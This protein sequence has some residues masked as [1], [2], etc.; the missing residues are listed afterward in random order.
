MR[1]LA[2]SILFAALGALLSA[3]CADGA[4]NAPQP[5]RYGTIK[6]ALGTSLGGARAW[7]PDQRAALE[8]LVRELDA[9]GPDFV[10]GSEADPETIVVRPEALE[11]GACGFYRLGET[12][13]SVDPVCT[14]GFSALRKAAAHEIVHAVL[15]TRFG[16][17]GHLC[18]FPLNAP[19]PAGCHPTRVCRE[20]LLSPSIQGQDSW[21]GGVEHYSPSVAIPEPQPEDIALVRDCFDRGSCE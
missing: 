17:R 1:Q 8:P 16:W 3:C 9:L 6:I 12:S 4:C 21:E 10:W 7:R 15:Y 2:L 13:V 18:W 5:S 14:E 19:V 20:C 11:A